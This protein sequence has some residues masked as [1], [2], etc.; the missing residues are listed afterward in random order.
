MKTSTLFAQLGIFKGAAM[1]KVLLSLRNRG[2]AGKICLC[3][4][5]LEQL[6]RGCSRKKNTLLACKLRPHKDL[7]TNVSGPSPM[8]WLSRV[9][10]S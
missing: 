1:C 4:A 6:H 10:L 8:A 2:W 3:L 9:L 5:S 7:V